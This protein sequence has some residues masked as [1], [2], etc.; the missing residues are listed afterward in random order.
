MVTLSRLT[1]PA[2]S[3]TVASSLHVPAA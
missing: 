1:A 2:V 3:V